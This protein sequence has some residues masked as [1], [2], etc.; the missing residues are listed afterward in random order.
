MLGLWGPLAREVLQT[1]TQ[2]DVSNEGIPYS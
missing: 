1:V 2:D